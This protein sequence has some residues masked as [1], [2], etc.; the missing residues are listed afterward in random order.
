ML[1]TGILSVI[2]LILYLALYAANVKGVYE[3]QKRVEAGKRP[4]TF[5]EDVKQLFD[6][7]F[8]KTVL[9]LPV[10]GVS[11]FSILPIVFMIL[12]AFTNY[13]GDVVPPRLVDWVG[14]E[15]SASSWRWANMRR[16]SSRSSAGTSSGRCS[17][18]AS[19]TSAGWRSRS[20]S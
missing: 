9:F 11:V 2:M 18:R 15:T 1:I 17:L 4:F 12:I 20:F 5:L 16:P 3:T 13:G 19:T 8:Y 7:K 14:F 6:Q 10:L